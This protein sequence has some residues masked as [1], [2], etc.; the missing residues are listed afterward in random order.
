M[1]LQCGMNVGLLHTNTG[2]CYPTKTCILGL[3]M[4]I[5]YFSRNN[6]WYFHLSCFHLDL[7]EKYLGML[8]DL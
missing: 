2:V 6:V 7:N 4:R 5:D 1:G 8:R 3:A